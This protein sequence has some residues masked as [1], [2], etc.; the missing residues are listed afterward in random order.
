MREGTI[1]T[2]PVTTAEIYAR[3][4]TSTLGAITE[5]AETDL[6][7][8]L[9]GALEG[10]RVL[11]I[12]TG[13]GTYAI[14]AAIRGGKSTGL[15]TEQ[16]MLQAARDRAKTRGVSLTL[17]RGDVQHLPFK[18]ETFDVVLA[19]TVLC[20]LP[21][22]AAAVREMARVL[23]PGGRCLLGDLAKHS[24]WAVRRRIRGWF[25]AEP[26]KRAQFRTRC[27][28]KELMQTAGLRPE[29]L[30]GGVYFPPSG[31][32]ARILAPIDPLL[33]QLHAPGAAFTV[34]TGVKDERGR[35]EAR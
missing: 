5:R 4:R 32:L 29:Q 6:V 19:I 7:F 8:E 33:S 25:G 23:V 15:D 11:D 34:V 28:L 12:G 20:F 30:R 24:V 35:V 27:E 3:W 17:S 16:E 22:P 2:R 10:K 14:E 13:D 26:W 18:P 1:E 9:A 31:A 21:D